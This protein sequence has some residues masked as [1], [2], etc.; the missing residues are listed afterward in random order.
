MAFAWGALS[1]LG[2]APALVS[3]GVGATFLWPPLQSSA[4][5]DRLSGL[6]PLAQVPLPPIITIQLFPNLFPRLFLVAGYDGSDR[7]S[8]PIQCCVEH[9]SY[10]PSLSLL[11]S[12]L[13]SG[14]RR[15]ASTSRSRSGKAWIV[16]R[17]R[18][19]PTARF[20]VRT[21][22]HSVRL[23]PNRRANSP[24]LNFSSRCRAISASINTCLPCPAVLQL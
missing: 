15:K 3:T 7:A 11:R 16:P 5:D 2:H 10:L 20:R 13:S 18:R 19:I 17:R 12:Y 22:T 24:S 8:I 14:W 23:T 21:A 9:M 4:R 1:S 6:L